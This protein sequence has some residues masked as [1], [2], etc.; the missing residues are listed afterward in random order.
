[1][2]DPIPINNGVGQGDP[3]LL[4]S[5]NYY[6]VDLLELSTTLQALGYVDDAMVM[7]IGEDYEETTQAI[8]EHMERENGGFKWSADHNSKFKINKLAIMHLGH[9]KHRSPTGTPHPL[10]RLKLMLQGKE[11]NTVDCYKYL[12]IVI[13]NKLTWRKHEDKVIDNA[14]KWV[15]QCQ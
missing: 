11:V 8:C 9:K 4:P 15:M 12:G 2:L 5:F 3:V 13:D 1:M 14:T 6:D 7:A 10:H